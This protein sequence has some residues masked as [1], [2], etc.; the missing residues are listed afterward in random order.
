MN[1]KIVVKVMNFHALLRV[2]SSRKKA[3]KYAALE[4]QITDMIVHILYNRNLVLDKRIL[5]PRADRPVLNLYFGSDYGFCG[6]VNAQVNAV[7]VAEQQE[8]KIV[9]GRKLRH[10]QPKTLLEITREDF[11][12]NYGLVEKIIFEAVNELKYSEINII[13]NHFHNTSN[14]E[15]VKKR[16]FPLDFSAATHGGKEDY[17]VEGDVSSLITKLVR[18]Y[19]NYEIKIAAVNCFASENILRQNTTSESL[20]KIEEREAG[21]L[22][23][24]RK[25]KSQRE[26]KKVIDG[27]VKK[28]GMANQ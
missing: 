17:I 19:V 16:I 11:D 20:K 8:S 9:I 3:E 6:G 26:F 21:T 2:D 12:T 15:L 23:T 18:A 10:N 27:F 1:T 24:Q 28:K 13:Y 25:E 22:M 14:I 7:L 4:K 5:T